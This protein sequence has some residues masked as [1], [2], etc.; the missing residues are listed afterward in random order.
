MT[1]ESADHEFSPRP[2]GP[3]T[4]ASRSWSRHE[5]IIGSSLVVLMIAL[6][7]P[8]FSATVS[9]PTAQPVTGTATGP[10][11]H[12]YLWFVFVLAL[13]ALVVLVAR[14]VISRLPGN[15]PSADQMLTGTTGLALLLTV[16]GVAFRPSGPF[17]SVG[18]SYGGFVAVL[19]AATA[20]AT[21]AGIA[22][23]MKPAGRAHAVLRRPKTGG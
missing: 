22:T 14:D 18:W 2:A 4:P 7:L 13:L 10:T 12:G 3:A 11:A 9:F 21:A 5:I 17:V 19:A 1:S 16:L 20:F 6:F 23:G 15:L 8:W